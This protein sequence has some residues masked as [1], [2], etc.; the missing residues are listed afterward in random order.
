MRTSDPIEKLLLVRD[1]RQH[2]HRTSSFDRLGDTTL[3]FRRNTRDAARHDLATLR[4]ELPQIIH[5]LPIYIIG[6]QLPRAAALKASRTIT[7]H[8]LTDAETASIVHHFNI[9]FCHNFLL[10][11]RRL[12]LG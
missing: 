8:V 2:C 1:E 9:F 12:S 4:D 7:D 10:A 3:I 11:G 5:V 6:D